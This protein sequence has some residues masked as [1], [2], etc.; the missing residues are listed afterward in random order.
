MARASSNIFDQFDDAEGLAGPALA[1]NIFDQFDELEAAP[2]EEPEGPGFFDVMGRGVDITQALGGGF[3]EATGE[4]LGAEALTEWGRAAREEN[5]AEAALI[6]R[7]TT[8]SSAETAGDYATWAKE[9]VAEMTPLMAPSLA[10]GAAGAGLGALAGPAA[11]IAIPLG[12]AIGAFVPSFVLGVGEVQTSIK[13][14]GGTS[15]GMAFLGGTAIG[16]LDS[17]VPGKLGGKLVSKLGFEAAEK[18]A[19]K[20]VFKEI[21]VGGTKEA[22]TEAAQEA[23]AEIAASLG[24]DVDVDWAA[25]EAQMIEGAAAGAL[26]G[27]GIS[28]IVEALPGAREKAA[29]ASRVTEADRRNPAPTEIITEGRAIMADILG[30][31]KA[32]EILTENATPSVGSRVAVDMAG[33]VQ[34]GTVVEAFTGEE[35]AGVVIDLDNGTHIKQTFAALS[36][37][38]VLVVPEETLTGV[39]PAQ[40]AEAKVADVVQ[41][42]PAPVQP[43]AVTGVAQEA[44]AQP[45]SPRAQPEG[46]EAGQRFYKADG[47]VFKTEKAALQAAKMRKDLKTMNVVAVP[48]AGGFALV[49]AAVPVAEAAV[50]VAEAAA[51][52]PKA[53][54]AVAIARDPSDDVNEVANANFEHP[55]LEGASTMDIAKLSGGVDGD[56]AHVDSL[57][58]DMK[59][60]EGYVSRLIVSPDG[61]VIEGQHR[62]EALRKLGA[63]EVPVFVIADMAEKFDT[64]A[65]KAAAMAG[66]AG[67]TD[68]AH[69]IVNQL[70][71]KAQRDGVTAELKEWDLGAFQGAWDSAVDAMLEQRT[72]RKVVA[73]VVTEAAAP[74][75]ET[76]KPAYGNAKQKSASVKKARA[77]L[78]KKFGARVKLTKGQIS[79]ENATVQEVAAV[80][81]EVKLQDTRAKL[82]ADKVKV[83]ETKA[84]QDADKRKDADARVAVREAGLKDETGIAS[85]AK[86]EEPVVA[87]EAV[88]IQDGPDAAVRSDPAK[89]DEPPRI[90]DMAKS[91]PRKYK[92][93]PRTAEQFP[94]VAKDLKARL[95]KL[96]VSD[97]ITLRVVNNIVDDKGNIRRDVDATYFNSVIDM[98]IHAEDKT[99]T[100]NHEVVHGLKNMKLF[101]PSEWNL[102]E[103]SALKDTKRMAGIRSDYADVYAHHAD[104]EASIVEEAIADM[105]ADWAKGDLKVSGVLKNL[106]KR[107]RKFIDALNSA[108][109]GQGFVTAADV[110]ESIEAGAV[111]R[112]EAPR[113]TETTGRGEAYSLKRKDKAKSK[114]SK[115]Y[116]QMRETDNKLWNKAKKQLKRQLLP[117]GNLPPPVL[118]EKI[119]RD[120]EF[121]AIEM[122]VKRL[123]S[124]LETSVKNTMDTTWSKLTKAEHAK[125]NETLAGNV[126]ETL[127]ESVRI[128]LYKL[129]QY[130]DT[131]SV[132]YQ[133]ILYKEAEELLAA[134]KDEAAAARAGLLMTFAENQGKYVHRSYRAF[135]DP[136]WFKNIPIDVHDAAMDYFID[137]HDGDKKAA[138]R[139]ME[140]IVKTG[141]AYDSMEAFIKES[142]LGA[143]DLSIL[144]R[145]KEIAPEVRALLGEH[146]D[147]RLNFAK[148]A[149]KM[150]QLIYNQHFLDNIREIGT[151]NFLFEEGTQ[152]PG[153]TKQIAGD[154]SGPMAP[155][156]GLYTFPDVDQAFTDILGKEQIAD[157]YR[158]LIMYNGMVKYGKTVASPTTA[159]RN[160]YSAFF[161][162]AANGHF[163]MKHMSKAWKSRKA[164]WKG[165]GGNAA[166]LRDLVKRGVIY[167]NPYAGEM[168]KLLDDTNL[169]ATLMDADGPGG[170]V[171]KVLNWMTKFYQYGD[172]FWKIVGYENEIAILKEAKGLTREQAEPLA[173]KRIRD[174][175][176]TYSLVGPGIQKLRRL[177]LLGT[178]VSFPAEIIRTKI[179]MI[180]YLAEDVKE[181]KRTGDPKLKRLVA[182]RALGLAAV[183]AGAFALQALS[184]SMLGIDDDEEEAI[185]ELAAPWSKNS[186]LMFLGR[187]EEGKLQY[188]DLSF[189][190]PYAYFKK[191][192][193]AALR[194]QP[195]KESFAEA[196]S[197]MLSPFLAPDIAAAAI[198]QSVNNKKSTGGQV[199]NPQDSSISQT[200]DIANHLKKAVQPGFTAWV[201][202][203][204]D[205]LQ[206][207]SSKSGKKYKVGD[208]MAALFGFR[209]STFDAKMALYYRSLNFNDEIRNSRKI[210]TDTLRDP[211]AVSERAIKNALSNFLDAREEAYDDMSRVIRAA[212]KSGVSV[213]EIA[214]LLKISSVSKRLRG[215]LTRG[216]SVPG[217]RPPKSFMRG[218]SKRAR[219]LIDR[220][221][222]EAIRARR[223]IVR[224][225]L[226]P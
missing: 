183:S 130:I 198:W 84:K 137:Q 22:A 123:V 6:P 225:A 131:M 72:P 25:V 34:K 166:Y 109:K 172:D 55:V 162:T 153:A 54:D 76:F 126:D 164:H 184:K 5:L 16:L 187:D 150:G 64:A 209:V 159:L 125:I 224:E 65:L 221:T 41:E 195:W 110:F 106:F 171:K 167:D 154:T 48:E 23:I 15:P 118:D 207:K 26:M 129:R 44:A 200:V 56:I 1:S 196:A 114:Y 53:F 69:M 78:R 179:N 226:K 74:T 79:I 178:F 13:E 29:D 157:W 208:E 163:D 214:Q 3:V 63:K 146:T 212:K 117:G 219:L 59:S 169:H 147:A 77:N 35:G 181:A 191:P 194:D 30:T 186:N 93:S 165:H 9:M 58:S 104:P 116:D 177:P 88:L 100:L 80:K 144:K 152:P 136:K 193:T 218:A 37:M 216:L 185:R 203:M 71:Q 20:A 190:D 70:L 66:G 120:G 133:E 108:L 40:A 67:R 138:F 97:K 127:P 50:P 51:P 18:V 124:S 105:Y 220:A 46:V 102:L 10:G 14:K 57:A 89:A 155:L 75:I 217:W 112:R 176:P 201:G 92:L 11:P 160:I 101:T 27:G 52:A 151:G 135:D 95:R 85:Q 43:A 24:A 99:W 94:Q 49:E 17:L 107:I 213:P 87:E 7:S 128:S 199:Y 206:D 31:N 122:D 119:K 174:T 145:R 161:F 81:A 215:A 132:E 96:G 175:Y 156:N 182:R 158:T 38:D 68:S 39:A 21:I 90:V 192:I 173:A 28:G 98:A 42:T 170:T 143:K 8:F 210:L 111:G 222:G 32:N 12:A 2:V 134:G 60:A 33:D 91:G 45:P 197:D 115:E 47:G 148:S 168:I 19:K 223:K 180:R 140:A 139:T 83:A 204:S 149:T 142:K 61:T 113:T 73:P 121:N 188:L 62:L 86:Q 4:A 189:L 211:N 141:T 36:D 82:R 202:R 103:N 205:A